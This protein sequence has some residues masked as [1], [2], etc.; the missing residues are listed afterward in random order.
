MTITLQ[1]NG[2]P[3][4]TRAAT[5]REL[6]EEVVGRPLD[7]S[8]HPVDGGRLGVAIAVDSEVVPRSAWAA[9]RLAA[10]SHVEL[11]TARQGG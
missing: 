9:H 8:G 6:V 2:E 5:A 11:V 10:G 4:E 3:H 7:D 1:L